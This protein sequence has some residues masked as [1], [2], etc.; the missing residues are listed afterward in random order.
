MCVFVVIGGLHDPMK[1]LPCP[2]VHD[3]WMHECRLHSAK[4]FCPVMIVDLLMIA[5]GL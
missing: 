1:V 3:G 5:P 4:C 2:C